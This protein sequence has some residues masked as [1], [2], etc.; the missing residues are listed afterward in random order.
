MHEA[1]SHILDHVSTEKYDERQRFN[2][3]QN[4]V[5]DEIDAFEKTLSRMD[6]N[7]D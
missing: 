4:A 1:S 5:V 7:M 3:S 2:E 6:E